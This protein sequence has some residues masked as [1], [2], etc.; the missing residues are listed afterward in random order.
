MNGTP[1]QKLDVRSREERATIPPF[2][3]PALQWV[4]ITPNLECVKSLENELRISPRLAELLA[5]RGMV[6]IEDARLFLKPSL[7]CLKDPFLVTGVYDAVVRIA[8]ALKHR[9]KIMILGDYDVDG[10]TSVA[11][12]VKVLRELGLEVHFVVPR[13][14]DEGYG[15]SR[16]VVDRALKENQFDLFIALDCGTNAVDEVAFLKNHGV[17]VIILDHHRSKSALPEKAI[18]V[19]PHVWDDE[20]ASWRHLSAVGLVFKLVH[21]L[22]K[23]LRDLNISVAHAIDLKDYLD[24]VAM[25]T[26]AD[27]VPL[28]RENRILVT[29]GLKRLSMSKHQGIQSLFKVSG[30]EL[31][32][33]IYPVDVS[34][35]LGPRI[36]ASGRLADAALPLNMLLSDNFNE[37]YLIA[38][39]LNHLNRQRQDIEKVIACE[40]ET[41][42]H[43]DQLNLSGIV[44]Y[45]ANWHSGV[46]GIVAGRL[47]RQFYRPAIVLGAEGVL[48][49]GSGRGVPGI[50]LVDALAD[51]AHLLKNWGGHPMAVGV[52]LEPQNVDAFR[53]GFNEAILKQLQGK[54]LEA[55]LEVAIW[56]GIEDLNEKLLQELEMLRP[57][58]EGNPEPILG[59]YRAQ[60]T[61]KITLFGDNHYRFQLKTA[62][63]WVNGVAWNRA[64]HMPPMGISLDLAIKFNWNLWNGRKVPQIELIN[65]RLSQPIQ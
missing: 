25:G 31:G 53:M 48:A 5:K 6:A 4:Y 29:H 62:M 41:V 22:L 8:L 37:A 21:G 65:W 40:A 19:N 61:S 7:K 24:F 14:M 3:S 20:M 11:L 42:V 60:L 46:V 33:V 50:N 59:V 49:K 18:L 32:Q 54:P 55:M 58:G 2:R 23:H 13:R 12:L 44:V 10:I 43:R 30:L 26:V 51:V 35:K 57:F 16:S 47:S 28:L 1:L 27:L 64:N 15:F 34:F 45:D 17:D 56:L 38:E 52:S 36:N 63:G 39:S 9:Q